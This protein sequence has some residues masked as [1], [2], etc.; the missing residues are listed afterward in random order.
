MDV[1]HSRMM[2]D[3]SGTAVVEIENPNV[4]EAPDPKISSSNALAVDVNQLALAN[5]LPT[6]RSE[7]VKVVVPS[8]VVAKS[9]V[10]MRTVDALKPVLLDSKYSHWNPLA[11]RTS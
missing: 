1:A 11:D 5:P 2:L 10:P 9:R 7:T 6:N 4:S 8:P 3:G